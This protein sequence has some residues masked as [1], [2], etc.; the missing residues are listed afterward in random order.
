MLFSELMAALSTHAIRLQREDQDLIVLGDDEALDDT[1]WEALSRHKPALLEM[2]AERDDDWLSPAFRITPDMLPLVQ[3][4][5]QA[6]DR[7]VASVP[8]GAANVQDIY[9]LA[10]LQQGMLY[11]HLSAVDG[12]P[13][14]AQVQ[15]RFASKVHLEAFAEALQWAIQRHDILRTALHW[16]Y[17]DEPVQVVWRE[18]TL[19]R[20]AIEADGEDALAQLCAR[21]DP[22]HY[23]LDLRQA[24]LMQLVHARGVGEQWVALLMFHHVVMDHTALDIVRREIQAHLAGES[25]QLPAPMPFRNVLAAARQALDEQAHERFFREMLNDIDEPTLAFGVPD[26]GPQPLEQARLTLPSEL[27]LRLRHQAR[28]LGVSPATVLH[29]GFARLLG[30]LSARQAVVF[31]SVLLGRMTTGEGGEQALGMFINTLPLRIDLGGLGVRDALLATHKRLS[32]LLGHEQASLALAQR[33]S[34]VAAPAPLFNSMLNYRHS[35][36]GDA[37]EIIPVAPG[38]D[39]VGA[40]E[41]TDYPLTVSVDD[42]GDDLR[43]TVQSL[44]QWGAARLSGQFGQVLASLVEA[45]EH[46]PETPLQNLAVLPQAEREQVLEQFNRTA[47]AYPQ[48]LTVH[49]LVEA[50][51]ARTPEACALLQDGLALS[52]GELNRR[53]NQL[54]QRMIER[55][56]KPGNRVALCLPRSAERLVGLLAVLKAG[57]AYVPVDPAY[58]AERIA[59]LLEDSQPALVLAN[60]AIAGLPPIPRLD[61]DQAE[62]FSVNASNPHLPEL[63]AQHLAYVVYT[64]GSTGQPKGVMIEHQTLA[65]LVHWHCQAFEL[66]AGSHSSSVA[67]FGFDALAWEVWPTLCAGATLHLPPAHIGNEHVDELLDWW[68]AQPLQVSFLPTPVAEQALRRDRQHPTLRTLLVGGDRLRTFERDPGFALVN[69]YGPTETTVVATSGQVIANGALHIGQPI[70]NTRVYVL[71]EGLQPLPVGVTGELFIGGAQVARG[72]FNR[73]ELTAERFFDDPFNPGGRMYRSGDLVRWNADGTLDYLGRND[74]QVKIRGVRVELGEI[75]AAVAA[76]PA[77]DDAVVLVREGRLL[78]WYTETAPVD[79]ELLRQALQASLPAHMLPWAFI[80]LDELPLTSHGKL[81]RRALPDPD[82]ALLAGQAYEAPQGDTEAAMAVIWAEVLGVERVGRHDNFFELGG[83]SLLAVTLVERLRKAGLVID[84]RVLFAQP[85]VAALAS[86]TATGETAKVPANRVPQGAARI[87]PDMLS[88]ID[89]DQASIDAIVATVPC[90]AANVQDIYPLAP[91]QEGILYHHLSAEQGDP[92]LLQTRL[93]FDSVER[94]LAWAGALQ[95]VIDRHDILRTAVHWQGLAQPLQV[96]WRAAE[97]AVCEV[98][99]LADEPGVSRIE[100]L[101]ARFDARRHRLD[102][103]QAP[104]TRLYYSLDPANHQV[105]AIL[106]FHHLTLDHTAMD[107]VAREMRALLFAQG[108]SLPAAVPYRNYVAQA[109]LADPASQ[110]AFFREMLADVDEPTLP[111]GLADVQGDGRNIDSAFL[112]LEADLSLR[113]RSQARQLGV[114]AA[115][116]MHLAWARVLGVLANRADVVF[117]TVLMGRLQGGEGADRALGMFINTLPLRVDTRAGVHAAVRATHRSLSALLGHEHAP[118]ALAQRCSGVAAS[119]PLFSALL[120]YRHSAADAPREGEGIWEGVRLLGGEERSNYPLTLSVN[121]LGEGFSFSVLAV[122]GIGAARVTQWMANTLTQLLQALESGQQATVDSLPIIDEAARQQLLGSFNAM[123]QAYPQ[124]HTVHALIEAQAARAPEATALC[125]GD[126]ALSYGDLNLRANRL[127]HRLIEQGVQCGDR[128]ALCLPRSIERLIGLLAVLK[129]GAAYVPVDPTYPQARIAYLLADSAPTLVLADSTI[130]GLPVELTRLDLD[131]PVSWHSVDSNPQVPGLDAHQLAYVVYT[132]GSTGQPKGVMIEHQTLANLVHWHCQAFALGAGER[133]SSVAGFGFDAMAWEVWPALCA[134]ATLHLPPAHIGNEHVEELLDW[135]LEQPLKVSFLPTPVAEQALRRQRQHPTLRT[136]LIGGDR[137]RQF[138]RDPGFAL[139]NNY[140]PTETT[141]VATSGAVLPGGALHIGQP[142]ANTRVYV[143]DERRQPVPVGVTGELYIGGGQV[144]R[145][146][147]NRPQLTEERFLADPFSRLAGARMYRS[148]DLVRWN[149]DGSLDYLGRNDDQVKIRGMR[150]ELGEIEA[151][152]AAQPGIEHAVVLVRGER[153]LA[154]FTEATAVDLD[155]LRQALQASLPAHMLPHAF[156]RLEQLPL[157]SHGKLDRRALPEPDWAEQG[158]VAPLGE[159]ERAIAATWAEVLG[160]ERVGRHDN[161]FELGGHSLLAVTLIERLRQQD[162]N[163]DVRV[164]FGQPTVAA[165]AAALGKGRQVVVP[166]NRIAPGCSQITPDLLPLI[167]LDQASIERI[168]ATVPGGAANV[169]DIYPLAPLQEGILYHHLSATGA[170]PYLLQWRVDFDSLARLQAFAGALDK[171]IARHDVLRTAVLWDGLRQPVQVVWRQVPGTVLARCGSGRAREAGDTAL[172]LGRAPLIRLIYSET[173]GPLEAT[174]QFHHI[175]L[176]HTAMKGVLDEIRDHLRGQQPTRPPVPYRNYVA[177]ARLAISEAEHEAFFRA[178]LGDIDEP[179]LPYGLSDLQGH[180]DG[181]ELATVQLASSHYQRLRQQAQQLGVSAASLLHLA[182]ARLVAATSGRDSVVFGTVLLGRLQGGA[183]ADHGLGMFINTLPLRLDLDGLGVREGVRLTHER[184]SALLVHEHASLALA[185]RCS[186]VA[187]PTPLFS[188]MLNYRHG[189]SAS[190]QQAQREALEGI[191]ALPSGGHGNYPLSVNVDDL[192]DG[193][194]M[195]AQ[196]TAQVGAQRVCEQ[197]LQVL[198]GLLDALEHQPQLAL[199]HLPVLAPQERQQLLVEA[200]ATGHPHDLQQPLQRLFE[201]QVRRTPDALALVAEEGE[202]SYRQ[203]DEQANRLAHHLIALGVQPDDRVAICIERGLT[204][205]VGLLAILKA[206]GAYV[207]VDPGYPA[208]R[209]RHMLEDSAPQALLVHAATRDVARHAVQLDLDRPN[210]N[211][212]PISNPRVTGLTAQHL[213][214]VIYTSGSTGVPKGVMVEHRNVVNLMHW[215]QRLCAS[216]GSVL[217]K[218]PISFDASVWELFWPLCSGLRL[219]LARPDGQR[220]GQYLA[221]LIQHQRVNVVQFVPAL[222]QQFLEQEQSADCSSLSDIVCGGGELTQA[223]AALV[224]QRLPGVRLHNVYGPT[225]TTVDCS[226]WTLEPED[227]LPRG[228]LPIGRPIDNT[229]L[230][231]L[232]HHDQPVPWGVAGHLHIGGAGVTRGYLGLAQQQAERFIDSPF[233]AGDRLYRSGD[234]VR[235]RVD[236]SLEFLGRNDQQVKIRGLRIEP[237]EIEACLTRIA[238]VREAVVLAFDARL[239]AYHTGEPHAAD[240]LRQALLTQ[241]PDYMVPAQYIHLDQLPLTPNGKLDRKALPAPDATLQQRAFEAPQGST[242]TLLA[243]IWSELLGVERVGR[244]DNFFEL[245]GHSLLAVSLT[246]R[247]RLQG[248]QVDVRTLFGQPTIAALAAT[249]GHDQQVEVPENR[250]P[251]GCRHIT[252]ALLSLIDLDQASIDRIVASVPGGAANVQDIYPLA[253]LQEGILYHHLSAAEHDPYVLYSRLRFANLERLQAFASALDQVVAR[254]DVLRTAVLWEGLPQP[255]QVVWRQ[256]PGTVLARCGSGRAREAGDTALDLGRAPLIRLVYSETAGP[257]EATLQFHHIVLDHTALEVVGE[258]LQGFLQGAPAPAHAPVPY[259]NYVAQARLGISQAEY[260]AFF[261]TQLA[262]IDAPTL[263]FGL[264]DVQG[265]GRDMQEVKLTLSS[266]LATRLRH[267]ARVLGIS[268]A[269]LFHL[270]WARLLGAASGQDRVVFGTVLLG[271]LQ[272]GEGAERALGMFINTLPLRI[273]LG[274]VTLREA[275]HATHQRLSALL[276]HE[277]AS[278]ALAQRCSGVA[279]PLPLFSAM[280]NYRHGAEANAEQRKAWQ[281]IEVLDGQERTNYPLSLNVDDLGEGFRLV[282]MTP[283]EVG[284]ARICGQM[285][286]V[287]AAMVEALEHE[288][289]LLLQRLPVLEAEE[290]Q[291]VLVDFND[292]AVDYNL[293]QTLHGLIEAQVART[294]DALAVRAEEG[295]LSYRQ[296]NEQANRLAHYLIALGVKPDD[297]VAICVERGL[298][299]VVGLLAILKAGGAYVPVDPDYPAER[300]RH[301]LTDSAPVAVLVHGATRHVPD[302]GQII[303]LDQPSWNDQ[304]ASNPEIAGLTPRHLAYVIYTSGST[305]LPKGV[306][307]EHAGVVNRLLWMQDAYQLGADDVVLQKTPFSFDVS[308]WEFL[309]P[310]QTGAR[311]V[312]AR[313]GGH[314]DPEYLRQVIRIEGITTLHFVP[315]MLDVFLSS[316]APT[317]PPVGA[318]LAANTGE[319]GAINRVGF[320]AG[321]PAPAGT[322]Y[323]LRRVLCS[324]EAL[325]GSLVR[326]FHTQLPTVELHNLYGPTEAAVDVSAWHCLTAPDNTPIGKPIANTALYVLD[327]QGQPVPQ[328]VAG[329]LFIGGV[330]VARGYLNRAELTAERF[331]D[332]P[333]RPGGRL[334]RTGDLARHLPDGNIEYLGRNDDQVK[335]RGLR[336]ELG[337]IQAGLTAIDGIKE[338]VVIARDQRLIAYYT[339]DP[340]STETLRTAL[341]AH[342]PEFMVPALFM[343]LN[344]LPLSPNG[345]LDRKAL[346]QPDAIQDRPYEAPQGDTETLLATIWCELLG[347]EQV[348][349]HDNFF[350]LGG[351][352]LLA[353]TLTSRLRE[354][355]LEADVR[356]L[357]DQPTLAGYAAITDRMEIVL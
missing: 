109:R 307:N 123:A 60:S 299:M 179:T 43:L 51:A 224:R 278:L 143:L 121:D 273:D 288:P 272:G 249:L 127:A 229:A 79:P 195:T 113:L 120:N 271:R 187:A 27:S 4:D 93:A 226:V 69:N 40:E 56:V 267:Q 312:M 276:A 296:L 149:A 209:I 199:Q 54:A 65:N 232:D 73:P 332:D 289:E 90:G 129:S 138:D 319:A 290:R 95:Q 37:A 101:H 124:G 158:Y 314:R 9:P 165:L 128:V 118:L 76:W 235:Q 114:S 286:Q 61:L 42:L 330:Q 295:E 188:A 313:P 77:V 239:V 287:L 59:Y 50:Q 186:G 39:I 167:E 250:I 112:A 194:R 12:D 310:L 356:A 244:H 302:A 233:V 106:L 177:Q 146:Y 72:Y 151:A 55:G 116:L 252:P 317:A 269:S 355:G 214:Y 150:V 253:P 207:P 241:L 172:D 78:A 284:A 75:E 92:Y 157:T 2:L 248:L 108:E 294:P 91:L 208:E 182:W 325:P 198:L 23:R 87:T 324:G 141:V 191:Q 258:E 44:P 333:F 264:S 94:L 256:V 311:L 183:G 205:V 350:E 3:L 348:S 154:W 156:M 217:H 74:D 227:E 28:Q 357:F 117:G 337:E 145:G 349:R 98:D 135:W 213:A 193:L 102:L 57:A 301:M 274:G 96:V 345:K 261:R 200:N 30:Q 246:A 83:H 285:N 110:E 111:L 25:T 308:V 211:D 297:R 270:A 265:D 66:A 81:D 148:G 259:R 354:Q 160:V 320:F 335:I 346:P 173:A 298:S 281:G 22:H 221:Q 231:V 122:K 163:T 304:P 62:A 82:G 184:L 322:A 64:S 260:E 162:L 169:Q 329:E 34:G 257:L 103:G 136:L 323:A 7:I 36:A 196:V 26:K 219:V 245:G 202:L 155:A 10:P 24:P 251:A 49:A 99:D 20:D 338:A 13:Y 100:Q 353:V 48:G 32:A 306:M 315:S 263:P 293:E 347:V 352:S 139:V 247:L 174:L 351:H 89:L 71:D 126:Q 234:L 70:A 107:V 321:E 280:L 130:D 45:L 18:A 6:I 223:L 243:A 68:L 131:Q 140:G 300:V 236:G 341:L 137:L 316:A 17:L 283:A 5:Q 328:G 282:A 190:E 52:Y 175:A 159:T 41:R 31:G 277:H 47:Q 144:A 242:E 63:D 171:V 215:S 170:D 1:L 331:F 29:L 216:A 327:S 268:V 342:L 339:G 326:R 220:D 166:E 84:V 237:G 153:L 210:W 266:T 181:F 344:A 279:A 343:H 240:T 334:Y 142:I 212:R 206:G 176:D 303:D 97:L 238:G 292:T 11:Q 340:Q 318:A 132:S 228:S 33:C 180:A 203:L 147:F 133:T 35:A 254:H 178:E 86:A 197:L 46:A 204:L 19:V 164:L 134:G 16:E 255:V 230:Y 192:G 161:F 125:Q 58:P 88:L 222:L 80:R 15:L 291:R 115:S 14:L 309:W 104:L 168:V 185:Q 189:A 21:F 8:G 225:E 152:M 119:V 336:I 85:T 275:A 305:G 201:A 38:I 262:D 218:T 105:V 53:A 67:G